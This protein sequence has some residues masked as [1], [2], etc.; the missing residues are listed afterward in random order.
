MEMS[1]V[2]HLFMQILDRK[3][4]IEGQ[5]KHQ[6]VSYEES[7]AYN[8]LADGKQP[9]PWLWAQGLDG[10]GYADPKELT[11]EQ[12]YS[13]MLFPLPKTTTPSATN[14]TYCTLP[15]FMS[16]KVC[17]S[18]KFM[19]TCAS[20][21]YFITESSYV[22]VPSAGELNPGMMAE[23]EVVE[24]FAEFDPSARMQRPNCR[25]KGQNIHPGEQE[26]SFNYLRDM[27]TGE[28]HAGRL[29]QSREI[30]VKADNAR[31]SSAMIDYHHNIDG[32]RVTRS[33]SRSAAQ[34]GSHQ[35]FDKLSE[36]LKPSNCVET[37]VYHED[38]IQTATQSFPSVKLN[39]LSC[40][41]TSNDGGSHPCMARTAAIELGLDT[42]SHV[43]SGLKMSSSTEPLLPE[44]FPMVEPKKLLVD[45][46]EED[47][48]L[49]KICYISSKK[50]N[51]LSLENDFDRDLEKVD[52]SEKDVSKHGMDVDVRLSN[53]GAEQDGLQLFESEASESHSVHTVGHQSYRQDV[54]GKSSIGSLAGGQHNKKLCLRSSPNS[55]E[56]H[57]SY[58]PNVS[59]E[60]SLLPDS[61]K[62]EVSACLEDATEKAVN[63]CWITPNSTE[64]QGEPLQVRYY[65][66]SGSNNAMNIASSRS[67]KNNPSSCLKQAKGSIPQ[68][69]G[70][71]TPN[72]TDSQGEPTQ[73]RYYLRSRSNHDMNVASSRSS[74][75]N[76]S[77]CLKQAE[78]AVP[79]ACEIS[80]PKSREVDDRSSNIF[81]ISPRCNCFQSIKDSNDC[82]SGIETES[83]L[84]LHPISISAET[85]TGIL[86]AELEVPSKS[87]HRSKISSTFEVREP[88]ERLRCLVIL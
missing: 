81:A 14:S 39:H 76:S 23:S 9:P 12:L 10:C 36:L 46:L 22:A 38:E 28:E 18:K 70:W 37:D 72:C 50:K 60:N 58:L 27:I 74:K 47:C 42:A 83:R 29:I 77:S 49:N 32:G 43:H 45:A 52:G 82:G 85:E 88:H 48:W 67:T 4:W 40:T 13:G 53:Y 3:Q 80:S 34:T 17:Q 20:N 59:E 15:A 75:S 1:R 31:K 56:N 26:K 87:L 6:I 30:P 21:K 7:L 63:R 2:E 62:S 84:E 86:D 11:T 68:A 8:V 66:R 64:T 65:L 44:T 19:E 35:S 57:G 71:I 78:D 5:L 33:R 54:N 51:Q 69:C 25:Q 24:P 61:N 73:S 41:P 55:I 16:N 79:Q